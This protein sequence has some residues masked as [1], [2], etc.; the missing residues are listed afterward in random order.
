MANP[1][2]PSTR[3]TRYKLYRTI[4]KVQYEKALLPGQESD[5]RVSV[6]PLIEQLIEH[7]IEPI[8]SET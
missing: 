5:R 8:D 1:G 7:S 3:Y 4:H 2:W 6:E